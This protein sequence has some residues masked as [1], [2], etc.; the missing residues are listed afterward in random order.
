[1]NTYEIA[2]RELVFRSKTVEKW[3]RQQRIDSAPRRAV[4]MTIASTADNSFR[5]VLTRHQIGAAIG[6]L[7]PSGVASHVRALRG[8]GQL[9]D[10]SIDDLPGARRGEFLFV[11]DP[12]MHRHMASKV[13]L[14]VSA[15]RAAATAGQDAPAAPANPPKSA[16]FPIR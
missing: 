12:R 9:M 16:T 10:L 11:L 8:W 15:L 1:M 4:F 7:C 13:N 5:T 14:D 6:G 2:L 3:A